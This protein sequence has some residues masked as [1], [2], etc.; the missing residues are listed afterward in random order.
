[1]DIEKKRQR[2]QATVRQIVRIYC[3]GHHHVVGPGGQL[4]PDCEAIAAYAASRIAGCPR[5]AVKTFC[6]V[7]PIHCYARPQQEQV[8]RIMR[9]G[10]PRMLLHHPLLTLQHM[11]LDWWSHH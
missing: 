2:E 10:G 8:L 7:C 5:M 4:C 1:M 9:Y 11:L 6:S 3:R